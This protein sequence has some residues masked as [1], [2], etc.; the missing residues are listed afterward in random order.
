[1]PPTVH[2]ISTLE[3]TGDRLGME[4]VC[5]LLRKNGFDVT[6]CPIADGARWRGLSGLPTR[7]IARRAVLTSMFSWAPF[8]RNGCR[9][10]VRMFGFRVPKGLR[11]ICA[12][13]CRESIL[14][15]PKRGWRSAFSRSR[16]PDRVIG[17]TSQD[18]F[19]PQVSRD[20][21][22][23]FHA[24]LRRTNSTKRLLETWK[25]HPEW[26][27]IIVVASPDDKSAVSFEA[28]HIRIIAQHLADSEFARLQNSIGF[29]HLLL[30]GE[31]YDHDTMAALSCGRSR[32]R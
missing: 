4:M 25:A 28:P 22:K 19:D 24:C 13:G 29:Q 3:G 5:S 10:P 27:E 31:S 32:S 8:F 1:M 17:F 21:R 18:H 26:P 6:S 12:N 2:V 30:R 7:F 20:Y 23:F 9:W 16:L 11:R 15:W 14:S